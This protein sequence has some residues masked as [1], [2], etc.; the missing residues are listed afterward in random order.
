MM[1]ALIDCNNFYASCERLFRPDLRTTPIVVLSNNDGCVIARSNEAKE[2]G[3][4]MGVPFFEIQPFCKKNNVH[5]F[6]SNY[7]LYGDLSHRVMTV[8]EKNWPDTEIYSIDEAFLDLSTLPTNQMEA[9]CVNI[10][11]M[12]FKHTGIPVSIGIGRTKTLAKVANHVAKK[13]LK[14]PVCNVTGHENHWLSQMAV[15]DIWGVGRQWYKKLLGLNI[16]NAL[17]L[18]Q[19]NPR[20]IKDRFNVVL[21]RTVL[22]LSGFPCLEL[23]D[24]VPKKSIM[25]SCSFG[26]LQSDYRVVEEA[27]SHHCAT[28]WAK[29]RRQGLMTQHLSVFIRSNPFRDDLTQYANSIGFR[30][31]NPTDDVMVLTKMAKYCL[32]RIYRQG[33]GYHKSG[34]LLSELIDKQHRQMDLFNQPT[35]EKLLNSEKVMT[36]MEGIN[37]KYGQRTIRLA[38]EGFR[39]QWSMKRQL[40]SPHYTTRWSDLPIAYVK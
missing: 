31:M 16:T 5:V 35:D 21:Q 29:M 20:F 39:K 15:D 11:K 6:S 36:T 26:G 14:I 10:Q 37:R 32:R 12:L 30:L 1:F 40:K 24:I 9:F 3:I 4:K 2:L 18:S 19:M 22:E 27:I 7:T 23:D 33:I 34:V 25:S 13:K 28:A 38:S 17:Q 8:I